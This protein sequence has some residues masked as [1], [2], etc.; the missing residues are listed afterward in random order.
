M[1]NGVKAFHFPL[2]KSLISSL[3]SSSQSMLLFVRK[4]KSKYIFWNC[5]LEIR[6]WNEIN[7]YIVQFPQRILRYFVN[8]ITLL[9]VLT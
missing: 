9:S 4:R 5:H 6:K 7:S 8:L 2:T 1:K 3:S